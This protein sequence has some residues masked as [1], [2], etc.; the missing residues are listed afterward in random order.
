MN[1]DLGELL[2]EGIDRQA[3]GTSLGPGLAA[4]AFHRHRRRL[5]AIRTATAGGTAIVAAAAVLTATIGAHRVPPRRGGES[6]IQTTAYVVGR[7]EQALAAAE[8]GNAIQEVRAQ[9]PKAHGGRFTALVMP[10]L[11]AARQPLP[12]LPDA[13]FPF[14]RFTSWFYHGRTRIVGYGADGSLVFQYGPTT[15]TLPSGR[16]PPP[17]IVAID[18]RKR[19]VLRPFTVL[20]GSVQP[21]CAL[22]GDFIGPPGSIIE[23]SPAG[24]AAVVHT[25]LSCG[26]FQVAGRQRI[27]GVPA[28]KLVATSRMNRHLARP[29]ETLWI[30]ARSFLPVRLERVLRT[31]L[32]VADFSW[33]HPTPA[34]LMA[35][36]VSVPAGMRE[37]RLPA[38]FVIV[39]W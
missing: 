9:A 29:K 36:R 1:S 7:A 21:S 6:P 16:Q 2:R 3:A 8:R 28:I 10:T 38:G 20:R 5:I 22:P 14:Q 11:R 30:N 4:R 15:T 12:H 23:S 17:G 18:Y 37:V 26:Q 24:W 27:D 33:L 25:A 34:N 39:T 13:N 19:L 32:Y 35:L 31:G